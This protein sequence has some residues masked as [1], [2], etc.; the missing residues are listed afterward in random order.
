M[1]AIPAFIAIKLLHFRKSSKV[2][3]I[4]YVLYCAFLSFIG[5]VGVIAAIYTDAH[6]VDYT[7]PYY[8]AAPYVLH[9]KLTDV[10]YLFWI[11]V[12]MFFAYLIN[13]AAIKRTPMPRE[14][15][16]FTVAFIICTLLLFLNFMNDHWMER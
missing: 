2:F 6:I 9:R 14:T 4:F 8:W 1:A 3:F 11:G 10:P 7:K 5:L 12:I 15:L 16:W 13:R